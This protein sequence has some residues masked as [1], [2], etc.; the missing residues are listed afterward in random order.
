MS[1]AY[2][3]YRRQRISFG[4]VL[5]SLL[6][7]LKRC[8]VVVLVARAKS[9]E[10]W[11]FRAKICIKLLFMGDEEEEESQTKTLVNQVAAAAAA[12]PVIVLWSREQRRWFSSGVVATLRRIE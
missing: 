7:G 9:G 10:L 2:K 12:A 3:F 4:V 8:G 5:N 6:N 1:L 11:T